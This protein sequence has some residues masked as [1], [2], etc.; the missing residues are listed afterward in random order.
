LIA[1]GCSQSAVSPAAP[2]TTVAGGARTSWETGDGGCTP[3][4]WKQEQHFDSWPSDL[5]GDDAQF[6]LTPD[7]TIDEAFGQLDRW[8]GDEITLIEALNLNGGGLNALLRHMVAALLNAT[9][10]FYPITWE[11]L[12]AMIYDAHFANTPEAIEELKD[13]LEGFNEGRCPLN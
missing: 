9:L 12:R 3:G 8:N 2:S 13:I 6:S 10:E 5:A 4:Y 11:D 7:M 1:A